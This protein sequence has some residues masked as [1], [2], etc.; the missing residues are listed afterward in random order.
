MWWRKPKKPVEPL[1]I[2]RQPESQI[3][4]VLAQRPDPFFDASP[5]VKSGDDVNGIDFAK[6][7]KSH[8]RYEVA[9]AFQRI[10]IDWYEKKVVQK[11]IASDTEETREGFKQ[12]LRDYQ[13][14]L[15]E[16]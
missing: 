9:I 10:G 5:W 6:K 8:A 7:A 16:F 4:V 14:E 3:Q 12:Y 11:K 1:P 13:A 15:E 2:P